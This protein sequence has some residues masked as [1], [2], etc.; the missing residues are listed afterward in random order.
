[1]FAGGLVV[2]VL[3]A[4]AAPAPPPASQDGAAADSGTAPASAPPLTSD[5]PP[6]AGIPVEPEPEPAEPPPQRRPRRYGDRGS[7]DVGLGLGYS[8]LAGFVAA[9]SFRYFVLD[10]VAPGVEATYVSGGSSGA[11]YGL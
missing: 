9:G 10:G 1:M 2:F 7:A 3:L 4:D 8:T 6:A 11:A 5:V